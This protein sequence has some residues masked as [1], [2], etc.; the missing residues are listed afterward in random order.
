[1]RKLITVNGLLSSWD[2]LVEK[3]KPTS[4]WYVVEV[5]P[6]IEDE[7]TWGEVTAIACNEARKDN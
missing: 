6:P 2:V 1:M 3:N 7:E 4:D 5:N